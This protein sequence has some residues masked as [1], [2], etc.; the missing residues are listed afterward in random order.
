MYYKFSFKNLECLKILGT[1]W[2]TRYEFRLEDSQ[3]I[4]A[5]AQYTVV[6]DVAAG[7]FAPLV[8]YVT[9]HVFRKV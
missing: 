9:E 1:I 3:K 2:V 6:R 7:N 8:Y 4:G 5:I